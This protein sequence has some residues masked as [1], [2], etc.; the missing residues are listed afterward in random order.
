[1]ENIALKE[2]NKELNIEFSGTIDITSDND[3]SKIT[4]AI[5]KS[6]KVMRLRLLEYDHVDLTFIQLVI[7]LCKTAQQNDIVIDT[8]LRFKEEDQ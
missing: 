6:P 7:S 4:K 3:L 8:D 1:M 5:L 2:Q